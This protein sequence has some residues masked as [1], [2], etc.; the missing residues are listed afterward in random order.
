[1]GAQD[2]NT[3]CIGRRQLQLSPSRFAAIPREGCQHADVGHP[4]APKLR[5]SQGRHLSSFGQS[6]A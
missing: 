1:M 4:G 3:R 6:L 5:D 2:H